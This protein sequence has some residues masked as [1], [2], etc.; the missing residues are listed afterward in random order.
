MNELAV[1]TDDIQHFASAEEL[2]ETMDPE[3]Y[4]AVQELREDADP[5]TVALVKSQLN[6]Y[7]YT[8]YVNNVSYELEFWAD[9]NFEVRAS[10]GGAQSEP[11]QGT[12]SVKKGYIFC[13]YPSI[14]YTVEIP[15]TIADGVVDIDAVAG[16]DIH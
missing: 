11:Q 16:F 6:G 14:N 9:N 3:G 12:Y 15:Y 5:D 7:Y 8:F 13:T 2:A 10:I 1:S 4:A